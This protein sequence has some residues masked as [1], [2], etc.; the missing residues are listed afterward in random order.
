VSRLSER[1]HL[2]APE[3]LDLSKLPAEQRRILAGAGRR[4][5]GQALSR[6][7]PERRYPML[8]T[9]PAKSVDVLDRCCCCSIR[10]SPGVSRRRTPS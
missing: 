6:R 5:T 7:E 10:R 2:P 9:L 8:L 4:L 1:L 3:F